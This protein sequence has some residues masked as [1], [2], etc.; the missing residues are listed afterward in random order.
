M[1]TYICLHK[2]VYTCKH[3]YIT[4]Y[5]TIDIYTRISIYIYIYIY[6]Y[7]FIHIHIHPHHQ[8]PQHHRH[9]RYRYHP[10]KTLEMKLW[11]RRFR[12]DGFRRLFFMLTVCRECVGLSNK[13]FKKASTFI[14][15]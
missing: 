2:Q 5:A 11:E 10:E 13:N 7:T 8:H 12:L 1:Y 3:M 6:A 14:I 15:T 9:H 4:T